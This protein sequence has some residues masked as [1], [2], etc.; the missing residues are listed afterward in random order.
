M[1]A[2]EVLEQQVLQLCEQI[3]DNPDE[4]DAVR[5]Q[6]YKNHGFES[7]DGIEYSKFEGDF[8]A[9]QAERDVLNPINAVSPGSAWWRKVDI[10]LIY[11]AKL[12]EAI[13]EAGLSVDETPVPVKKWLK[14]LKKPSA[15]SWFRAFNASLMTCAYLCRADALQEND[16]EQLYINVVLYRLMF[17]QA[18]EEGSDIF[19]D[20]TQ[21][22][23][24]PWAFTVD[25]IT[26]MSGLHPQGYPAGEQDTAMILGDEP[27]S[28]EEEQTA[29]FAEKVEQKL[30]SVGIAILGLGA[31]QPENDN[32]RQP[33]KDL[34][35]QVHML[36]Q[37]IILPHL[38]KLYE[39][40]AKWNKVPFVED[41]CSNGKPVYPAV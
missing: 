40:I 28:E 10:K 4:R 15:K 25:V 1:A 24:D 3:A 20:M 34:A 37:E 21:V 18:M 14:Y 8:F 30:E 13:Y 23:D 9:H 33:C 27:L 35:K 38:S 36:D 6:F 29:A 5:H 31:Q 2:Y 7:H 22:L 32:A 39:H 12:A 41:W 19:G 16:F 11:Y 26:H 17:A